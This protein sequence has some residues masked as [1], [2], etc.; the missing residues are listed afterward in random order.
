MYLCA[1]LKEMISKTLESD[2]DLMQIKNSFSWCVAAILLLLFSSPTCGKKLSGV[3]VK[4]LTVEN[5]HAPMGID[6]RM[7]RFGWKITSA[8][9]NVMQRSYHILV[10]S[11]R[12]KL[13]KGEGDLWDSGVVES[14]SSQW[15]S[16]KGLPLKSNQR[17]YWKVRISTTAG[18]TMWSEPSQWSMGLLIENHWRGR[19]IGLDKTMPWESET[20]W[21]RLG[22]RYLRHEFEVKRKVKQATLHICGLGLYEAY[23][24]GR[25][26]GN[27]VLAPAPTDY[28]KTLLYNTYDVTELLADS[29]NSI[30]VTLGNGRFYHM[31]QNF[32]PYKSPNFGYP[33]LRANLIIEY[34]GGGREVIATDDRTW[35]L[36][37]DGPI[38][39]N[40][41]YDGEEYDARKELGE[42]TLPGYDDSAWQPAQRVSI[43]DGTLRAQMMPHMKVLDELKPLSVTPHGETVILDMGQNMVG[44]LRLKRLYGH[45]EGDTIRLR[46]AERLQED[47]S[48]YM[49]NLRDAK[50][51]DIYVCHGK[52][53]EGDSWAPLFVTHGFRYVE[54]TGIPSATV[55]D[56]VGEVVSDEMAVTGTF[57]CSD[58]L[59]N[60]LHR[61]AYWGILGNYKG[62]PIDCPQRNERQPWL[63]DRTRGALGESF[64]FGNERLYSKW[65]NDIRE[66]QRA[67]GLIPDV[68]PAYWNYYTG[69]VTW[70]AALPFICD[71]LYTQYGNVRPIMENYMAIARWTDFLWSESMRD[72]LITK[73]K[74]G[75]WCVPPEK[76]NLVHSQDPERKTD[77]VLI[78]SAYYIRQLELM[79]KFARMQGK[80]ADAD[81]WHHRREVMCEAFNRKFLTVKKGT[82]PR[83]DHILYPDSIYYGNNTVTSNLLPLAIGIVPPEYEDAVFRHVLAKLLPAPNCIPAISCGVIG[84]QWLMT[85]LSRRGRADVAFALASATHYPSWGYMVKQGATTIW[86]LW[87]GNTA[88]PSM[89]SGNHVMLLGDLVTWMY[90]YVGGIRS[91]ERAGEEGFK[92]II[93]NPAFDIPD[94]SFANV[95]YETPYGQVASNWRKSLTTYHWEVTVPCNTTATLVLPDGREEQVGSGTYQ[96]EGTLPSVHPAVV[97]N[98]FLYETAPFPECHSASIVELKNGD[99]L[100]TYF[101]GTKERNPDVCIWT[102]RKP[103]GKSEWQSPRKVADGVY[104]EELRKA[105]SEEDIKKGVERKACWNPVLFETPKGELLLFYKIGSSVADWTGWLIRSK[106]HG[107][108]WSRPEALPDGFLGP[109]KN[110]PV[111]VDGKM[112]CPSSTEVGGWKLHFELSDD[113]GKTWRMVGPIPADSALHTE[114]MTPDGLSGDSTKLRPLIT[115]QPAILQLADGFLQALAR[116]RNGFMATTYSHDGGETWSQVTLMKQLPQNNS[117]I[118]AVTSEDGKHYL[119]YNHFFTIPSTPKGVRTPVDLAWSPDGEE[120]HHAIRLEGSPVKQYSYPSIIQGRDGMLHAVY[121]WRRQRIK[122]VKIDPKLLLKP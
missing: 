26:V 63:G 21:S 61:N 79:E 91:G 70:P 69:D 16:Y 58:T 13:E 41:E 9:K 59:V 100:A 51:T 94:L 17:A 2:K 35:K 55:D 32:K 7:P 1:T 105:F 25:K 97:E 20:Q 36:T 18:E 44:W 34:E 104:C 54:V 22:A 99:L 19:W 95:S 42:W 65:M 76:L 66:S 3:G 106:N 39:S 110:K 82:S 113:W 111:I 47:G 121:T 49:D 96:F 119:I 30:G 88:D 116:T 74:Y 73:D 81:K 23:I 57:E 109:I 77:G 50:V 40:N 67:D 60:R 68:A 103:N 5:L 4:S 108:S 114:D 86:E 48:L 115:I 92:H 72:G 52:E 84:V 10:A 24:N 117:G 38:R 11:T 31:R 33:K 87:N 62:M 122:Y 98:Q 8:E 101:G 83:P 6:A 53:K 56:F 71:I 45:T 89:N 80:E 75:D 85:E 37:T 118:D 93:L 90:Q 112:I 120:W 27:Q 78:A 12:E 43:P 46:F 28:R 107:K 14:D 29:A 102:S 64:I 15:V